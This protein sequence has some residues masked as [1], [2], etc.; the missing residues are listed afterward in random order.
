MKEENVS[1]TYCWRTAFYDNFI[2]TKCS[3]AGGNVRNVGTL[4]VGNARR[5]WQ[6]A[7]PLR[8]HGCGA[9]FLRQSSAK[10][11]VIFCSSNGVA[12]RWMGGGC[13]GCGELQ[14]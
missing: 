8:R 2:V 1:P 4:Q 3:V 5:M 14:R 13:V 12:N 10:Q 9:Q 7:T 6:V 11:F